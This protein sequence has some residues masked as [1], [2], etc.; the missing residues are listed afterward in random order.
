MTS[1]I[2]IAALVA[3]LALGAAGCGSSSE[4]GTSSDEVA[5]APSAADF[6]QPEGRSMMQMY[7][8]LGA[9]GGP[10]LAPTGSDLVPGK[11]RYGFALFTTAR[12]QISGVPVAVYAQKQGSTK[13][14]GPYPARDLKPPVAPPYQSETVSKDPDAAKTLYV[15]EVDF[16][17]AGTYAIMG[18]AK[19]DGRLVAT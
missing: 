11:Q 2:R 15:S 18:V 17:K 4:G 12:K 10:A 1:R 6:P 19:L 16:P 8:A 14:L 3:L 7:N 5:P 13:V 9:G